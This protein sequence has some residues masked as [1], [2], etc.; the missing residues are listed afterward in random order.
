MS[1]ARSVRMYTHT[2]TCTHT[3]LWLM[4][5]ILELWFGVPGGYRSTGAH[6]KGGLAWFFGELP[7]GG[8]FSQF[9]SWLAHDSEAL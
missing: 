1:L 6:A 8:N 2:Y 7:W 5:L 4:V 3:L 9:V